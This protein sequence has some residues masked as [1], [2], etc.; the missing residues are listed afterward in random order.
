MAV[1]AIRAGKDRIGRINRHCAALP[2]G[3]NADRVGGLAKRR[4]YRVPD[5]EFCISAF[6][7]LL[8]QKA[9]AA[10]A[11]CR[12]DDRIQYHRKL[13][14]VGQR[15]DGN[16]V[17]FIAKGT[18]HGLIEACTDLRRA[19]RTAK[20]N[21]IRLIALREHHADIVGKI[22][23]ICERNDRTPRAHLDFAAIG[24]RDA[25][26]PVAS[27]VRVA[28]GEIDRD[29]DRARIG[30]VRQVDIAA[31]VHFR[32]D[33]VAGRCI[34]GDAECS[35]RIESDVAVIIERHE[36][37]AFGGCAECAQLDAAHSVS[38]ARYRSGVD[39]LDEATLRL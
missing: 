24:Q 20:P 25:A 9:I 39:Y 19:T 23:L 31:I 8:D 13:G 14:S 30:R 5:G 16:P 21:H 11:G 15:F 4:K 28:G 17:G 33:I 12:E 38:R 35:R 3:G 34:Q 2:D 29:A 10:G 37:L 22:D 6:A 36:I 26:G 18:D 7:Q 27:L 32:R 1:G